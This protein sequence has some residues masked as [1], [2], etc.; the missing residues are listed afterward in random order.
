M[1]ARIKL[2]TSVLSFTSGRLLF[3]GLVSLVKVDGARGGG[4]GLAGRRKQEHRERRGRKRVTGSVGE[5]A[6]NREGER[7]RAGVR[8]GE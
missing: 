1:Y 2:D 6:R 5:E 7:E 8:E 4:W 3:S